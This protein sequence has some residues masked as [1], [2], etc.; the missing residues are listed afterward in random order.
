MGLDGATFDLIDPL[1]ELDQCPN[2]ARLKSKAA[3]DALESTIPPT[4]PPAWTTCV[5]G[6][7]PGKH[8]I[9]D[10]T[11]SPLEDPAQPLVS[12]FSSKVPKLWNI[13][14]H[15]NRRAIVINVPITYPP[16]PIDGI[17][18]SGMMTPGIDSPFTHPGHIRDRLKAICG[19]YIT[20]VDIPGYDIHVGSEIQ[21]FLDDILE[22]MER[23]F[24]AVR[25]L[26]QNEEWAMFMV[27]FIAMD[28]IQH[29]FIKYLLPD[30]KLYRLPY[31]ETIRS[32]IWSIYRRLDQMIGE[33][34]MSLPD[35]TFLF[36]LSD[37]GF[38]PTSGFFNA[39]EW[40]R[41]SGYL[42]VKGK[43]YFKRRCFHIAMN[44]A[45]T[46][47]VKTFV[48]DLLSSGIRRKIRKTRS[49]LDSPRKD[50]A[51]TINWDKTRAFFAS[52][53]S[54]GI[55]LNTGGA[56]SGNP[57]V[58]G[59]DISNLQ[60]EIANA[61][62][63]LLDPETGQPI[64]DSIRLREQIYSGPAVAFAPHILFTLSNYRY[65]G[66][67]HLGSA[68]W[69]TSC[70]DEPVGFHRSN[71]IFYALGPGIRAGKINGSKILD[72]TPTACYAADLPIPDHVD[73]S[74]MKNLFTIDFQNK[75]NPRFFDGQNIG[76]GHPADSTQYQPDEQNLVR[77]RLRDLGYL[78]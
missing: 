43:A 63:A 16:E 72:F 33:I 18:I 51:D 65:L 57:A 42:A 45:E 40:L 5:T 48:P 13:F 2:L 4:T 47:A 24:E 56:R 11:V 58:H 22:S 29:L 3:W 15:F 35:D 50:L 73:G 64:A 10:F 71:G 67:Q 34:E 30:Q 61:L 37:H 19:N 62:A 32:R 1:I 70:R 27:V 44:L 6:C 78:E 31:A 28:R 74:V 8:G 26:M 12:S 75:R 38:G 54:Q 59:T 21:R 69:F 46:S 77:R 66:R 17:M 68:L 7:N 60:S 14:N 52:I 76:I 9:F 55:Y 23:R 53:P 39:N 20:N 41:D 49:T 36:I 25:H